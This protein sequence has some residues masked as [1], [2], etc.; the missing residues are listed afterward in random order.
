LATFYKGAGVDTYWHKYDARLYGLTPH[1]AGASFSPDRLMNHIARGAT[2][3]PFVSL[4]ASYGVAHDYALNAGRNWPNVSNPAYVYEIEIGSDLPHLNVIDPIREIVFAMPH[5]VSGNSYHHDGQQSFILGIVDP[6]GMAAHLRTAVL[7]PPPNQGTPRPP[8][9]S[10]ALE[11]LVRV[12]RDAE[13]IAYGAV[14]ANCVTN[15]FDV[16]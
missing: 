2:Y 15:R 13:I 6:I 7:H 12:L 4:T 9:I 8:N 16:Y 5:P 14:P 1:A 10:L 3:T 11:T